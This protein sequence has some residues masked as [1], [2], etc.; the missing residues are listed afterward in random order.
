MRW[1]NI[2]GCAT[3]RTPKPSPAAWNRFNVPRFS[4]IY[5]T[6]K[7]GSIHESLYQC[8]QPI[9]LLRLTVFPIFPP[10]E[11]SQHP[12]LSNPFVD[13]FRC[14]NKL[15]KLF[16]FN[17]LWVE[18]FSSIYNLQGINFDISGLWCYQLSL[19]LLLVISEI[20]YC[21]PLTPP[22]FLSLWI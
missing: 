12:F 3:F 8:C 6:E 9:N 13:R 18:F 4:S 21:L 7:S 16:Q 10:V 2:H 11:C 5:P 20:I 22:L 14:L 1:R 17:P 19:I 15:Y